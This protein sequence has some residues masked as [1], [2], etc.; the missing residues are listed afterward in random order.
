MKK[1]ISYANGFIHNAFNLHYGLSLLLL[2]VYSYL[3]LSAL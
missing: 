2:A 3:L 1:V